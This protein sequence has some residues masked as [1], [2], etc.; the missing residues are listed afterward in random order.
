MKR[1]KKSIA[2]ILAMLM[3][4]TSAPL[5]ALAD[6]LYADDIY[7][8][9]VEGIINNDSNITFGFNPDLQTLYI[10]YKRG[11]GAITGTYSYKDEKHVGNSTFLNMTITDCDEESPFEIGDY[12]DFESYKY[13]NVAILS[14]VTSLDSIDFSKFNT[15]NIYFEDFSEIKYIG[16]NVFKDC[17]I[18][19][20]SGLTELEEIGSYAF[21]N[22]DLTSFAVP[23]KCKKIGNYAF[24]QSKITTFDF[25]RENDEGADAGVRYGSYLAS[26]CENL[27]TVNVYA[28]TYIPPFAFENSPVERVQF[29]SDYCIAIGQYAFHNTQLKKVNFYITEF[30][31]NYA[32]YDT[33]LEE[34][35]FYDFIDGIDAYAFSRCHINTLYFC[36]EVSVNSTC[37]IWDG[38]FSY[39]DE[40][41]SL[42]IPGYIQSIRE[43]AF[44]YCSN[45]SQVEFKS[46]THVIDGE[47]IIL[48]TTII[49]KSAFDGTKVDMDTVPFRDEI[50]YQGNK[51]LKVVD[52]SDF[53]H[54]DL[55]NACFK[56]CTNLET[57][58]LPDYITEIPT[59]CFYNCPNLKSV[60]IPKDT[61]IIGDSAFYGCSSL[62]SI[63]IPAGVKTIR[64]YAFR[65]SSVKSINLPNTV[66]S[67]GEYAFA[68]T[69]LTS[70]SS[71]KGELTLTIGKNAFFDSNSLASVNF[72]GRLKRVPAELF[73]NF[74]YLKYF[75]FDGVTSI[76]QSAF[77][78]TLIESI[79]IGSDCT[80]IGKNA[81]KNCRAL[82]SIS[83]GEGANISI[84][85]NAFAYCFSLQSVYFTTRVKKIYANAF[86]NCANLNYVTF[87][88][89]DRTDEFGEQYS[90]GV[91]YISPYAFENSPVNS[92]IDL[93]DYIVAPPSSYVPDQPRLENFAYNNYRI[94]GNSEVL[95]KENVGTLPSYCAVEISS[96][97]KRIDDYAFANQS[98]IRVVI[99]P[100]SV[101]EIGEHAFDHCN[102]LMG[103]IFKGESNLKKVGI[104]AFNYCINLESVV[105]KNGVESIDD[106][107]F[108]N[109]GNIRSVF[110]PNTITDIGSYVF[111]NCTYLREISIPQNLVSL[112]GNSFMSCGITSAVLPYSLKELPEDAFYGA[113]SLT[114]V[115]IPKT[116]TK[117]PAYAFGQCSSLKSVTLHEGITSI[118]DYA[119]W[120]TRI[121]EFVL[122]STV[123]EIGRCAFGNDYIETFDMSKTS[124]KSTSVQQFYQSSVEK[125]IYNDDIETI[126]DG[127]FE[128]SHISEYCVPNTVKVIGDNC[129]K[130][131]SL[132]TITIGSN[133]ESIGAGAFE[134]TKITSLDLSSCDKITV[135]NDS[136][137]NNCTKLRTVLLPNSVETIGNKAFYKTIIGNEFVMPQ[138]LKS[139]GEY[140]FEDTKITN[141]VIPKYVTK[142]GT[143]AFGNSSSSRKIV[144]LTVMNKDC[145][146][147]YQNFNGDGSSYITISLIKGIIDSPAYQF[148]IDNN[149]E[150]RSIDENGNQ[151]NL[152]ELSGAYNGGTWSI[153]AESTVLSTIEFN[154]TG[155][156]DVSSFVD[157]NGK[158]V[159][160]NELIIENR[161]N[162]V[163][164]PQKI[165]TIP[166]GLFNNLDTIK[167]ITIPEGVQTIGDHAFE[168]CS[169][170]NI[171][172]PSSLRTIGAYAF[173]NSSVLLSKFKNIDT[174]NNGLVRIC[175]Y[176]F[177]G[178]RVIFLKIPNTV[179]SLGIHA[180]DNASVNSI[181]FGTGIKSIPEYCFANNIV[182][183]S[184]TIPYGITSIG[185]G[186]FINCTGLHDYYISNSVT[187][188]YNKTTKTSAICSNSDGTKV[189]SRI[190]CAYNSAAY[191]YAKLYDEIS[192]V[193][194]YG[195][196]TGFN[197][198]DAAVYGE[199]V[200]ATNKWYYYPNL[201][202]IYITGVGTLANSRM[203]FMDGTDFTLDALKEYKYKTIKSDYESKREEDA[204]LPPWEEL[205]VSID[206]VHLQFGIA[207]IAT[208][209]SAGSCFAQINPKN[210]VLPESL[211]KITGKQFYNCSNL[212][213]IDVPDTVKSISTDAFK[214]CT[215]LEYVRIGGGLGEI[216]RDMFASSSK[217][218][219]LEIGNGVKKIGDRAFYR[220]TNLEKVVIPDSV[221]MIGDQSFYQCYGIKTI[222]IGSSVNYIGYQAFS[223]AVL[224]EE[225]NINTPKV[226]YNYSSG[227]YDDKEVFKGIGDST[228]GV[229]VKY[230][231]KVVTANLGVFNNYNVSKLILGKNVESLQNATDL[232]NLTSVELSL[233][234][235]KLSIKN[236]CLYNGTTLMLVPATFTDV[237]IDDATTGIGE[238]AF[239]SSLVSSVS[240][241]NT[242]ESIGNSAFKNA[243]RLKR[244]SIPNS[245]QTIGESAFEN[246]ISL[247]TANVG[248]N[249]VS[250][251]A[252]AFKDCIKLPTLILDE[253][254]VTIGPNAFD[255]CAKLE[256]LVVPKN[257]EQ[258]GDS[259]FANCPALENIFLWNAEIG[260]NN[261]LDSP[262]ITAWVYVATLPYEYVRENH[263]KNNVYT[264]IDL[265]KD[266]C[267][268]NVDIYAGY[269]GFCDGTHGD[270]EWLTVYEAD[271]QN[272]GYMIGVCEY[273]SEIIDE[274]H[275][276]AS[277]HN[278]SLYA[279]IPATEYT[280]G[281]QIFTCSNCDE[282]YTTFTP[283]TGY[284]APEMHSVSGRITIAENKNAKPTN[285][286]I[287]GAKIVCDG[288]VIAVT[289]DSGYFDVSLDSGVYELTVKY[290]Y[291]I[292]R[293]VFV[294]VENNDIDCGTIS[295]LGC[296]FNK[297]GVIN[298]DD[299]V[300]FMYV[301]SCK[302]DD[303]SYLSF[304]DLNNDGF[305]N[306]RDRL[307]VNSCLGVDSSFKYDTMVIKA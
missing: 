260:D 77:E 156:I 175:D 95:H 223:N 204:T 19:D 123:T 109:C 265:F 20:V 183:T 165:T 228:T 56:D 40:L 259:A 103:V 296:D 135:I 163:V 208:N 247:R 83:F 188:I 238:N 199:F 87:E 226:S 206:K 245:V 246:C 124:L 232:I 279:D 272:D 195:E 120:S 57:V 104:G 251:G 269:L 72:N 30:I 91:E 288:D 111:Y 180:F 253:S 257:V 148:A 11:R 2:I 81:F 115:S 53:K 58:I 262:N 89:K 304:V 285:H 29:P 113:S 78:N 278:Y 222:T 162:K 37:D 306:A 249:V 69:P 203:I 66:K 100:E 10:G 75:N 39:N 273:C 60:N 167:D 177:S 59:A 276:T 82:D 3:V 107:A 65:S 68:N 233:E 140:A 239:S 35:Y 270:I 201:D 266:L 122:P 12:Y 211:E 96:N 33:P 126:A 207:E 283:P 7:Q 267:A 108:S 210:I 289:D 110:L 71:D 142:V 219:Y 5:S 99:I 145:K 187:D 261:F 121:S 155:N 290:T 132:N 51:D 6:E 235:T 45:L 133:V 179:T 137:A 178:A 231:D 16:D 8:Y 28:E 157:E 236:D 130:N 176:A 198:K 217:L 55:A 152:S 193:L 255:G 234:N 27:N 185:K 80:Y 264:D 146:I 14:N 194:D 181:E 17:P 36:E 22:S 49:D 295:I 63:E 230:G 307:I 160:I 229:T 154:G 190:H 242:I 258:I 254:L 149:I 1:I 200:D 274:K 221:T 43:G 61:E 186:A 293:T 164:F 32:F 291:G 24:S 94:I 26:D 93:D 202:T 127:T 129:F 298:N 48:R 299:Y 50:S 303:E 286:S 189:V 271:C 139:I 302:A 79:E 215:G 153:L 168:N 136:F 224:C 90:D 23:D 98:D 92:K 220:C 134:G 300:L 161:V 197:L 144:T 214:G 218:K 209:S 172:F 118:G 305:I 105:F 256:G 212:V 292:D 106:N 116:I 196:T 128:L 166:S 263:I 4:L 41:E 25:I 301:I 67:I 147:S 184:V 114:S 97:V 205:E 277:G 125:I 192:Y 88:R 182:M 281:R 169:V 117:I 84:D 244:I 268:M 42:V 101:E 158:S 294:V 46:V 287:S 240:L 243:T 13:E 31:A 173:Y 131:S 34:V 250:I 64:D 141:I 15:D 248:E 282:T 52:L 74:D 237:D 73:S 86:S 170:E 151:L 213:G 119:F 191:K 47:S 9:F 159:D 21:Y 150:F 62:T 112:G 225:L 216:T 174:F 54:V 227:Y 241:P 297:D 18:K 102:G 284:F 171:T 252:R 38:A 70:I 85:E 275:I 44:A 76:N 143:H 280:S 138:S